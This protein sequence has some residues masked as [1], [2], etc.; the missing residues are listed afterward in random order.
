MQRVQ[1]IVPFTSVTTFEKSAVFIKR[2]KL[3]N[4]SIGK[5]SVRMDVYQNIICDISAER[6]SVYLGFLK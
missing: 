3:I 1:H 6:R 4:A 5:Y 2:G